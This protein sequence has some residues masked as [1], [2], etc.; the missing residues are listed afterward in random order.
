MAFR[1]QLTTHG[2]EMSR[3]RRGYT[4]AEKQGQKISSLTQ[5]QAAAV[6]DRN[7]RHN[8]RVPIIIHQHQRQY[9]IRHHQYPTT[10][11]CQRTNV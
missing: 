10:G 7:I 4:A 2:Y 8:I 1:R 3:F 9:H 11:G 5:A 6:I